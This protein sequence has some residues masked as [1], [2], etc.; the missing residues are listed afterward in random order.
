MLEK[1]SGKNSTEM[2]KNSSNYVNV[3]Q[4]TAK[5]GDWERRKLDTWEK[6]HFSYS[7]DQVCLK[8]FGI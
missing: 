5:L 4:A 3:D 2:L 8:I 1:L 7:E 6:L